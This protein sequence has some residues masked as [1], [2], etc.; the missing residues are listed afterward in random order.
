MNRNATLAMFACLAA[1]AAMGCT[2]TSKKPAPSPTLSEPVFQAPPP[3]ENPA[4]IFSQSQAGF[5]FEDNRARHI[6]DIVM[7]NIVESSKGKNKAETK[8][9]KD[10]SVNMGVENYFGNR[11]FD[12]SLTGQLGGANFGLVGATG[13][14]A[15]VKATNSN[16]FKAKG[17][18]KRE[19]EVSATIGCRVV[20][21]LP[22]GV[23]QVEGARETRVNDENQII[24]VRGLVRPTDIDP[25]NS[26]PSTALADCKIEYY[27]E[28]VL[29]DR[30]KPGW[31]SRLLDNVWPF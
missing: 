3:A 30:Q 27:G 26:V 19:S 24:V 6:G 9:D 25:D 31:L 5:L 20:S 15:M 8:S 29:A 28:G 10:S 11:T 23:M 7:V 1:A 12:G 17:E 18:T 16:K 13:Q 21:I 14:N 22:G 4:S 2:T